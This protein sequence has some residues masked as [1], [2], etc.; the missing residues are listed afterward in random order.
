MHRATKR[1]LPLLLVFVLLFSLAAEAFADT[2]TLPASLQEI[3][4][5]AFYG[6]DSLD[7]VVI[8]DGTTRV[9]ERAFADSGVGRVYFPDSVVEIADDA[10]EGADAAVIVSTVS[11][12]AARYA[13][14]HDTTL[15]IIL[16]SGSRSV[17][18]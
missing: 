7:E 17:V 18:V 11:A 1:L 15:R 3:G 6:D 5:E 4:D 13:L 2:L 9:G 8:P 16:P 10:F 12:P 14:K